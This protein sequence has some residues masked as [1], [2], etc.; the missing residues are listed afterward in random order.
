MRGR[1]LLGRSAVGRR[2]RN[3]R[4]VSPRRHRR[5]CPGNR[6]ATYGHG[7]GAGYQ[8]LPSTTPHSTFP[9]M[10][11]PV[12]CRRC[13]A[14][15]LTVTAPLMP[16]P[17]CPVAAATKDLIGSHTSRSVPTIGGASGFST[18]LVGEL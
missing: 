13:D 16:H 2:R 11:L 1:R 6:P 12:C 10:T 9:L 18:S 14:Y 7:D 3:W 8:C 15:T 4:R 17:V 5:S